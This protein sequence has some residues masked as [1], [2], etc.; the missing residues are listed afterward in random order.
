MQEFQLSPWNITLNMTDEHGNIVNLNCEIKKPSD[1]TTIQW[2]SVSPQQIEFNATIFLDLECLMNRDNYEK[3]WKLIAYYSEVPVKLERAHVLSQEPKLS[4]YYRQ[5]SDYDA[6]YYTGVKGTILADPIWVMQ[7]LIHIQLNR[8]Q[9]TGKKVVLTFS[10]QISQT[11]QTQENR[12][13]RSSWVMIEQDRHIKAAQSV[14]EGTDAQLSCNVKASE[15][16]AINWVLPDGTKLKA[17]FKVEGSRFSVLSSGQ[18]IIRSAAYSDAGVYHCIAQVRSDVDRMTYRVLVQPPV[19]QPDDSEVVKV[20]KYVG[21]SI[22]LPCSAAA[23]PDA[24]LSWILPSSRVLSDLSNSSNGYM[25]YNG[26]LFIPHSHVSDGGYYRCVAV[27]QQGSD[28]F[29]VKVVVNKMVS[30]RASKRGK[31]KKRPGSRTSVKG[32]G[33]V[34]EDGDGSGDEETDETLTKR[35]HLKGHEIPLKQRNDNVPHAQAKKNKKGKRKMKLWKGMDRTEEINVAEGRRPFESRRRINMANKQINPQHWA[36]ILAKVRG[37]NLPKATP[38]PIPSSRTT[39]E[40]P[41][42][43]KTTK[44]PPLP[45]PIASPPLQAALKNPVRGEESSGDI[46]HLSEA[47]LFSVTIPPIISVQ[48]YN[49]DRIPSTVV[50]IETE[51][52]I[53]RESSNTPESIY[54]MELPIAG[55]TRLSPTLQSQAW[56]HSD[57]RADFSPAVI[58]RT[59]TF[60][61]EF[62]NEEA[63]SIPSTLDIAGNGERAAPYILPHAERPLE[64]IAPAELE[65]PETGLQQNNRDILDNDAKY[66]THSLIKSSMNSIATTT[67]FAPVSSWK[68]ASIKHRHV[69]ISSDPNRGSENVTL[70]GKHVQKSE[71]SSIVESTTAPFNKKVWL[72]TPTVINKLTTTAVTMVQHPRRRPFGKRRFR[73]NR[74]RRPK[75]LPSATFTTEKTPFIQKIHGTELATQRFQ[76][77]IFKDYH[78]SDTETP[79]RMEYKSLEVNSSLTTS[80][81]VLQRSTR[82]QEA[83]SILQLPTLLPNP[84]VTLSNL[85]E[86][87]KDSLV[88]STHY[89]LTTE[90]EMSLHLSHSSGNTL[91][92]SKSSEVLIKAFEGNYFVTNYKTTNA[93]ATSSSWLIENVTRPVSTP[94]HRDSVIPEFEELVYFG[95]SAPEDGVRGSVPLSKPA[96]DWYLTTVD[97][98]VEHFSDLPTLE[99]LQKVSESINITVAPLS[100]QKEIVTASSTIDDHLYETTESEQAINPG[101]TKANLQ[102]AL[103]HT[104]EKITELQDH[105]DR[106]EKYYSPVLPIASVHWTTTFSPSISS[107]LNLFDHSSTKTVHTSGQVASMD[108]NRYTVEDV[109]TNLSSRQNELFRSNPNRLTTQQKHEQLKNPHSGRTYNSLP[110]NPNVPQKPVGIIPSFNQP[111][112]F[113][114][115]KHIPVRGTMKPP[116]IIA[117][118]LFHRFVTHRPLLHFTNK[119]EITAY[120]AHTTQ[121]RKP[122]S[123]HIEILPTTTGAPLHKP[124]SHTPSRFGGHVFTNNYLPDTKDKSGRVINQAIPYLPKPRIPFLLNRTRI[125]QN[126]GINAKSPLPSLLLPVSTTEKKLLTPAKIITQSTPLRDTLF[127]VPPISLRT[128][129]PAAT[130]LPN[131]APSIKPQMTSTTQSSGS[132]HYSHPSVSFVPKLGV[133]ALNSSI[134]QL[135][136]NV[137]SQGGRPTIISKGSPSLSVLAESDAVVPCDALGEPKPFLSWTKISTG[138]MF[139]LLILIQAPKRLEWSH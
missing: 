1:S 123:R 97:S 111:P 127:L 91:A 45:P 50:S 6:L 29:A 43:H 124:K 116:Y 79:V 69:S 21:D 30:D 106:T 25:L 105:P 104:K 135:S 113:V 82:V 95:S 55:D 96:T 9:S 46:S 78:K 36:H 49:S 81:N 3:L 37:K 58:N 17:P 84:P 98:T 57:S 117:P 120:A 47:E 2:N 71:A 56:E 99:E 34:I 129:P 4:Y 62:S 76:A 5:G 41:L 112:A 86:D 126:L 92:A 27:N 132:I 80:V 133:Q 94:A 138:K 15:S 59:G 93:D 7:P 137:R 24:Y 31:F 85:V 19:I 11:L 66:S 118:G 122:S 10:T 73:P 38:A 60:T 14:V 102:T 115:P 110:L 109:R 32:K 28:Q 83:A 130:S 44:A 125:F 114:P 65:R 74:F 40:I 26:T 100:H 13:Q 53:E 16:P 51:L 136:T 12:Q 87:P 20:E 54:T 101:H 134:I 90:P 64:A 89:V 35:F 23:V 70:G 39:I 77:S 48:D 121:D 52:S 61:K 103:R 128:V 68:S 67:G 119:P 63:M 22:L 131:I 18:L 8:R 88:T 42:I 107:S 139:K 75:P 33:Q 108:N 72:I